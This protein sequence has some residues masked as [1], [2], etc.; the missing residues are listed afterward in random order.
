M[1]KHAANNPKKNSGF[2]IFKFNQDHG[3][4]KIQN[5]SQNQ[6]QRIRSKFRYLAGGR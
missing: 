2:L 5:P 4:N 3:K 1:Q 6:S